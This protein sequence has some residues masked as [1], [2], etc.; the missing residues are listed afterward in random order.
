MKKKG[1]HVSTEGANTILICEVPT[2]H[3]YDDG[4]GH[5]DGDTDGERVTHGIHNNYDDLA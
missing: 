4:A 3:E 5:N 1:L 2:R